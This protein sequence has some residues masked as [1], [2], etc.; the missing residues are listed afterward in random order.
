MEYRTKG[1][2]PPFRETSAERHP[3]RRALGGFETPENSVN[4]GLGRRTGIEDVNLLGT[5]QRP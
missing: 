5:G 1:G 3:R 2:G 4:N